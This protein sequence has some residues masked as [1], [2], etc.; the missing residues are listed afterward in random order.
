MGS[1]FNLRLQVC[2]EL[3]ARGF[4]LSFE[5]FCNTDSA[6]NHEITTSG[7]FTSWLTHKWPIHHGGKKRGIVLVL[8][9]FVKSSK[10]ISQRWHSFF[11]C[12]FLLLQWAMSDFPRNCDCVL[13]F[14]QFFLNSHR[15]IYKFFYFFWKPEVTR[16]ISQLLL[17][18]QEKRGSFVFVNF[19]FH[20]WEH[21]FIIQP[22][23]C[24]KW[25]FHFLFSCRWRLR[26]TQ[27]SV[28][29][30]IDGTWS[31][32]KQKYFSVSFF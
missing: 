15:S 14:I 17:V 3:W 6:R 32:C 1:S 31:L 25:D 12:S 18:A 27:T 19:A 16:R 20:V 24:C 7:W 9:H 8:L 26:Q 10:H 29:R 30:W 21:D 13:F 5:V 22:V 2:T 23:S 11:H 4:P 28:T